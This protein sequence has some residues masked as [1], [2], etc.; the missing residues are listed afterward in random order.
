[1]TE[2]ALTTVEPQE[3]QV[4]E[5]AMSPQDLRQQVD[6]IQQVMREVMKPGEHYGVIPGTTKPT[7]FKPGAEKLGM[8]FR[9]DPRF[10]IT[11]LELDNGHREYE[12][13]CILQYGERHWEGVGLCSSMESKYRYR[14]AEKES[15]GK[16]V[17]PDYWD[18]RKDDA[19]KAQALLGGS[20]FTTMKDEDGTWMIAKKGERAENPDIADTY[21]TV[22]KMAKKRAHV[23]AILT[24][25]AASDIFTQDMEDSGKP[26]TAQP[27]A[28]SKVKMPEKKAEEKSGE[29]VWTG[30]IESVNERTGTTK[31]R[32]WTLYTVKGADGEEFI[33]FSDTDAEFALSAKAGELSVRIAWEQRAKGGRKIVEISPPDGEE[34]IE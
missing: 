17:P 12:I 9:L 5:P 29:G 21:N 25:T 28:Q 3:L 20:G 32:D 1:M 31:G 10:S 23:D 30:Q 34:P 22:L 7:L 8:T 24:A 18:L 6:L 2:Q 11:R 4:R 19:K 13:V 27:A 26:E 16:R 15:T 14:G 33:T